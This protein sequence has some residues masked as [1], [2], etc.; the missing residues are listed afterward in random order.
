MYV[1]VSVAYMEGRTVRVGIDSE[2]DKREE[3][4]RDEYKGVM[5]SIVD[6]MRLL[7]TMLFRVVNKWGLSSTALEPGYNSIRLPYMIGSQVMW[8]NCTMVMC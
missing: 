6:E 3:K 2:I 4:P 8:S 7:G 5:T 1:I